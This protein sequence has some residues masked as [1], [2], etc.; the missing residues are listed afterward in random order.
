MAQQWSSNELSTL[1]KHL[2]D[3]FPV[4]LMMRHIPYRTEG[5]IIQQALRR[6]YRIETYKDDGIKRFYHGVTRRRGGQRIATTEDTQLSVATEALIRHL[7][8]ETRIIQHDG[9]SANT[10]A[11]RMLTENNLSVDPDIVC[12]LSKHILKEHL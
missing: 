2:H 12:M 11:V 8:P 5:A 4:Y 7:E 10:L 6:N 3:G 1:L 9:L